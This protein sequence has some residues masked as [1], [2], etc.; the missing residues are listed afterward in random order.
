MNFRE[1]VLQE[2]MFKAHLGKLIHDL[3]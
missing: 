1:Q 2:A 3:T